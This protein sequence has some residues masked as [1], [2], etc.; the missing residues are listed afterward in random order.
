METLAERVGN[1]AHPGDNRNV[2]A[3]PSPETGTWSCQ[4]DPDTL[5]TWFS[6][7]LWTFST[8]GWPNKTADLK[9]FHPTDILET[10]YEIISTWVSRMVMLS[11]YLLNQWPFGRVYLHGI[12]RDA[13]G[14]K[15]SKSLGNGIDPLE[16]IPKYGAD[17][18]RLALT[19]NATPGVD[20][21]LSEEKIAGFRNFA[22]KLWNVGRFVLHAAPD[23]KPTWKAPKAKTPAEEWIL[24]RLHTAVA[25]V[26]A[27]LENLR[28]SHAVETLHRFTWD[29]LADWYL[30][31]A[32]LQPNPDLLAYLLTQTL[33]AWHPFCPFVTEA[34]WEHFA[35][36][37]EPQ[38][39]LIVQRWP[40][41]GFGI[42]DSGGPKEFQ[43]VKQIIT[44]FRSS[45]SNAKIDSGTTVN[46]V[47]QTNDSTVKL[48]YN[49]RLLI[50][51]LAKV[52]M[53][54]RGGSAEEAGLGSMI[55]YWDTGLN[56]ERIAIER[57]KL[58]K[59]IAGLQAKLSD[60]SF[61]GRAPAAV[62]EEQ[63]RKLAE[64]QNKL[65]R[66]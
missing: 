21:K 33:V 56:P 53:T 35:E 25:D 3:G 42:K 45:K 32:K 39:L 36:P 8:L 20:M 11:H 44:D 59:Y 64:A 43:L 47:I 61:V 15:M 51:R 54:L 37:K 10:G 65:E 52:N 26:T 31:V 63:R 50:E 55:E 40:E 23:A 22:N 34:I 6:S 24:A 62:V 48:L 28:F 2:L 19:A 41:V 5:D 60:E 27:D 16:I 66:V 38:D 46:V 49:Y 12:V 30:E 58:E 4:R 7:S 9:E 13:Q 17:A 18:L 14:R 1:A 57:S 29:E